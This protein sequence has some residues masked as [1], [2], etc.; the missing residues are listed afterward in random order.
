MHSKGPQ[1]MAKMWATEGAVVSLSLS[2]SLAC[3]ASICSP[4]FFAWSFLSGNQQMPEM[5]F[6]RLLENWFAMEKRACKNENMAENA[7]YASASALPV[8]QGSLKTPAE[9]PKPFKKRQVRDFSGEARHSRTAFAPHHNLPSL[10]EVLLINYQNTCSC[11][12]TPYLTWTN[13]PVYYLTG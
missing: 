6:R 1:H 3:L 4:L 7:G 12:I 8:V 2:L 11:T 10:H 5:H 9:G 13:P